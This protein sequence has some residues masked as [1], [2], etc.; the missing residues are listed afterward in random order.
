VVLLLLCQP[1]RRRVVIADIALDLLAILGGTLGMLCLLV[2]LFGRKPPIV[3]YQEPF[4]TDETD[5]TGG[6]DLTSPFIPMPTHLNTHADMISW[7]T[8]DLP[9]LV[10]EASKRPHGH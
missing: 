9:S 10:E 6:V 4:G 7:M 2:V 1:H 5:D 3:P 8:R